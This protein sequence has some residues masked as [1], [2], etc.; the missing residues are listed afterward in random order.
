MGEKEYI[1]ASH[2]GSGMDI[3]VRSGVEDTIKELQARI[4]D[5]LSSFR[6][7]Y[8]YNIPGHQDI[9]VQELVAKVKES[10]RE[11]NDKLVPIEVDFS[12][13]CNQHRWSFYIDIDED[14]V[15][16][17]IGLDGDAPY[18]LEITEL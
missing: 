8:A 13:I 6:L 17:N 1:I 7:N 9:K 2:Q 5:M 16:V 15:L 12:G 11:D 4:D 18:Y 14:G 3:V 10:Y